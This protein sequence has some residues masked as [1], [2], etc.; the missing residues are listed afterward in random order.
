MMTEVFDTAIVYSPNEWVESLHRYCMNT[1]QL[2]IRSLVYDTSALD[3]ENVDICIISESHPALSKSFVYKLQSRKIKVIVM[4]ENEVEEKEY[5]ADIKIDGIFST[6]L[7]QQELVNKIIEL[8]VK[9]KDVKQPVESKISTT[10]Q[11]EARSDLVAVIGTGGSGCSEIAI[12]LSSVLKG[13][14][15]VDLDLQHPSIAMRLQAD[16]E[17]N[18]VDA[19]EISQNGS[20]D[21]S[22]AFQ[23]K[24]GIQFIAGVSHFSF[25]KNIKEYEIST[26]FTDISRFSRTTICDLGRYPSSGETNLQYRAV[27]SKATTIIITAFANPVGIV[28]ILDILSELTEMPSE[29]DICVILNHASKRSDLNK[30]LVR[31]IRELKQVD[32]VLVFESFKNDPIPCW[33]GELVSNKGFIKS[34]HEL[35]S[36]IDE[37]NEIVDIKPFIKNSVNEEKVYA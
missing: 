9:I 20:T 31:E 22:I 33:K 35:T 7:P 27:L 34:I 10:S 21:I 11:S 15:L 19:I 1:G 29:I 6:K 12:Q 24:N 37:N 14:V 26:L 17:P 2:R 32:E 16:I 25:S 36:F 18:I 8:L 28:R 4:T 3:E 23:E 30:Q 13:A 5:L